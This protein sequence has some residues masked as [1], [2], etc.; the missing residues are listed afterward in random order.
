MSKPYLN[1]P[2]CD[3]STGTNQSLVRLTTKI[4]EFTIVREH[5][6]QVCGKAYFTIQTV[7]ENQEKYRRYIMDFRASKQRKFRRKA[8]QNAE[9]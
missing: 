1:C 3:E 5:I 8:K 9:S 7:P 6:C 4:D 2:H